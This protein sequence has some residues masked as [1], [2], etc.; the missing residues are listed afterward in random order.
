MPTPDLTP[1]RSTGSGA[2]DALPDRRAVHAPPSR[3]DRLLGA[4]LIAFFVGAIIFSLSDGYLLFHLLVEVFSVV[5]ACAI[6]VVAWHSRR[7][8][9]NP[10]FLFLGIAYLSVA[11]LDLCHTATYESMGITL[12]AGPWVHPGADPAI[13]FWIAAR[14]VESVS[15]VAALFFV[16]RRF[17]PHGMLVLY[18]GLTA[19]IFASIYFWGIFPACFVR[20]ASADHPEPGLTTFK[21]VSEYVVS[22]LMAF[23][24][25]L[26]WRRRQYFPPKTLHLLMASMIITAVAELVFTF[27]NDMDGPFN[28]LGH[29][30]KLLSFFLIYRATIQ[31]GLEDPYALLWRNLAES[32]RAL[33]RERDFAN[34]ILD[35][36][37]ALIVVV[38]PGGR[39]VRVNRACADLTGYTPEDLA[40]RPLL[41]TLVPEEEAA[42]VAEAV[43]ALQEC[44][45]PVRHEAPRRGGGGGVHRRHRDRR[46]REPAGR[47]GASAAG[48][49]G[50]GRRP[51]RR[52]GAPLQQRPRGD[53]G[54]PGAA[55]RGCVDEREEPP[56]P[57]DCAY[58][59]SPGHRRDAEPAALRRQGGR[60]RRAGG[61][62]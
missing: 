21:V 51:G 35:T 26:L 56:A 59:V 12:R 3:A 27:Y 30:C 14:Y 33:R 48:A 13:E 24:A 42:G 37:A 16:R 54:L 23:G 8:L 60:G 49:H 7:V 4:F 31:T 45:D 40:G 11:F 25:V 5:V 61:A 46:H 20:E 34:A 29:F 62:Q 43:R 47:G 6:F 58:L 39:I 52:G 1:P 28:V 57:G 36:A 38:D 2:G 22:G 50:R 55:G 18:V 44:P 17:S 9:D 19:L 41:E 32:E 10:F 15:L 53:G